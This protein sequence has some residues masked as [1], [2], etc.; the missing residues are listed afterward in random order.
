MRQRFGQVRGKWFAR[1]NGLEESGTEGGAIDA[2]RRFRAHVLQER[3]GQQDVI[4]TGL[5]DSIWT[6]LYHHTL[7]ASWSEFIGWS[8]LLYLSTNL[9]FAL[10]Y[11]ITSAN[12]TGVP[13]H[14][15]LDLFFF[16]VQTLST[17]GYG[18]M[19]PV[20]RVA[21]T[22]VSVEALGG[23]MINALATGAVFARFSRPR[24]RIIFSRQA[25]ISS[26]NNTPALCI[27]IA[28]CRKSMVLSLDV[29]LA[30]SR[31]VMGE[32][33]HPVR[34]FIPMTLLQSHV[35][36][37]RFAFVLAHVIDEQ[38]P[39]YG[40]TASELETDEAEIVVTVTGTDEATGQGV[41]ARTAYSFDRVLHDH[42]FVDIIDVRPDG[43][44]AVDYARFHDIEQ[45]TARQ[46]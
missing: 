2:E 11:R 31:L 41:L 22:I 6:D 17:V 7:T 37:L 34:R 45:E 25:V 28:N 36:V 24:A 15:L 18:V 9:V 14:N 27:R 19:A 43:G 42:R 23:M 46:S 3:G 44:L 40:R 33:S 30:L 32:N 26:E 1:R 20:G 21:N 38:S 10:L 16:S 5:A 35:P 29:E 39:L 4:R 8:V 12:I 13:D